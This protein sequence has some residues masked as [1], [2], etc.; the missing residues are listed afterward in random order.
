MSAFVI[1]SIAIGA[2]FIGAGL[3]VVL[4]RDNLNSQTFWIVRVM[5]ALGAGFVAAGILGTFEFG[6]PWLG[7]TIKAGGPIGITVLFYLVNP[8]SQVDRYVR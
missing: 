8:G 1:A 7:L 4:I 3:T 5:V 6:G 2:V